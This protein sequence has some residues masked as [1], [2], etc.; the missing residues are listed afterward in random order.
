M[1]NCSF[2]FVVWRRG[3]V[4][5]LCQSPPSLVGGFERNWRMFEESVQAFV[6]VYGRCVL[7]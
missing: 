1:A 2:V 3:M 7:C 4:F 5:N 6:L